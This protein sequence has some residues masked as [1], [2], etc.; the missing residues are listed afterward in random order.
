MA[1]TYTEDITIQK[2]NLTIG[3]A[4]SV[5]QATL[6]EG[7][8][9]YNISPSADIFSSLYGL[10]VRRLVFGGSSSDNGSYVVGAV[11]IGT[12]QSGVI[13]FSNIYTGLGSRDITLSNCVLYSYDTAGLITTSGRINA[14]ACLFTQSVILNNAF[15]VIQT[16]GNSLISMFGCQVFSVNNT[17]SA[18]P[19]I[20]LNND[21]A[22]SST[23]TFNSCS[24]QYIFPTVN[25]GTLT[26]V[27]IGCLNTAGISMYAY[28]NLFIGE[29]TRITNSGAQY[30]IISKQGTGSVSITY[31]QN[32]CGT[33]ANHYATS[34]SR[35]QLVTATN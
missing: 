21:S 26:K 10:T 33:T 32:L 20:S 2:N 15:P 30:V 17:A 1:G 23:F 27:C 28:N 12:F 7:V 9:T 29:G 13:P 6:I 8:I 22:P 16:L 31:G 24:I 5:P 11:V 3:G 19:I 25:T 4:S 18:P 34:A 35:T 14:T